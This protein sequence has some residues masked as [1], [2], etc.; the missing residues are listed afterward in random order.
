MFESGSFAGAGEAGIAAPRGAPGRAKTGFGGS[1]ASATG[2]A[3][4]TGGTGW[5]GISLAGI[6][7]LVFLAGLGGGASRRVDCTC[8]SG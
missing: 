8:G 7:G 3:G 5:P 2:F 4:W 6:E 1:A